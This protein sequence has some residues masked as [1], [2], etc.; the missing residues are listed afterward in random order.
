MSVPFMVPFTNEMQTLAGLDNGKGVRTW[1]SLNNLHFWLRAYCIREFGDM[2]AMYKSLGV[3]GPMGKYS[4]RRCKIRGVLGLKNHYY[5]PLFDCIEGTMRNSNALPMR[6]HQ[7][8][9]DTPQI[10][11][12]AT[13]KTQRASLITESGITG[14][15][16]LL[17]LPG[18]DMIHSTPYDAMHRFFE[19][20]IKNIIYLLQ[21]KF[22]PLQG[23]DAG[24]GYIMD[25]DTWRII[26][27]ETVAVSSTVPS[28]FVRVLPNIWTHFYEYTSEST[29]FFFLYVAPIVFKGDVASPKNT[30]ITSSSCVRSSSRVLAWRSRMMKLASFK[31]SVAN[32]SLN[33][34]GRL[35]HY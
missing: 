33:L 5:C 14:K 2:V 25:E 16:F 1:N 21:G 34:K 20:M 4:C 15:S 11:D 17:Q 31:S 28:A 29:A 8:F 7:D 10:L 6:T 30:M 12:A 27:Q 26:G 13:S 24:S 19:N 9:I 32:L 22:K 3:V 35:L 18:M 23:V